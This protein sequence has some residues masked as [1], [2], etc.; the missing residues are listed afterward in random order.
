MFNGRALDHI[1]YAVSDLDEACRKFE[2]LL[3]VKPVFGG[4]HQTQGTKNALVGLGDGQYLELLAIDHTNT[5]VSA[6][7]W[8]GI[9]LFTKPQVTRLAMKSSNLERDIPVLQKANSNMGVRSAGSRK[10]NDGT[11]LAWDLLMPLASPEVEILPFMID[12]SG[13]DSHPSDQ[14]ISKCRL[15]ELVASHPNPRE[16]ESTLDELNVSLTI[17]QSENISIKAMIECPKGIVEI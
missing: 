6:P 16:I 4:Y 1:V 9:D 2:E 10:T 5:Q 12:W 7:R 17:K 3:G 13:A 14:L 15:I 11:L 8:M